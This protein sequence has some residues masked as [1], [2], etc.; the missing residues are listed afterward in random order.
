VP[1]LAPSE[2][3]MKNPL[4][5]MGAGGGGARK[6]GGRAYLGEGQGALCMAFSIMYGQNKHSCGPGSKARIWH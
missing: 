4:E 3:L 5:M 2:S 6:G 1:T